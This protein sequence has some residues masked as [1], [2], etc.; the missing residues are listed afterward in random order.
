[1]G[2]TNRNN[3]KIL[4]ESATLLLS[5]AK[6]LYLCLSQENDHWGKKGATT[7]QG[8][9]SEIYEES[10]KLLP[11]FV[12]HCESELRSFGYADIV[13]IIHGEIYTTLGGMS[14]SHELNTLVDVA[15]TKLPKYTILVQVIKIIEKLIISINEAESANKFSRPVKVKFFKNT[16]TIIKYNGMEYMH[17]LVK[18]EQIT[19]MQV[20]FENNG[21]HDIGTEDDA[22][23]K[24]IE[25]CFIRLNEAL[26][27]HGIEPIFHVKAGNYV[28]FLPHVSLMVDDRT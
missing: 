25:L 4:L 7:F 2:A 9:S 21:E 5:Q 23:A 26:H 18:K 24:A 28:R 3:Q 10:R 14:H 19:R 20:F 15:P 6:L 16:L 22:G 1:M 17:K 11:L 13:D 12:K 27:R 8:K